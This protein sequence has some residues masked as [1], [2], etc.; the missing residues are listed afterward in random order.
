MGKW[1]EKYKQQEQEWMVLKDQ[2]SEI[3]RALGFKG[4][5]WFDDPLASHEEIV[6]RAKELAQNAA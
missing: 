5:A 6:K 2:Y 1:R 3:A 4:D